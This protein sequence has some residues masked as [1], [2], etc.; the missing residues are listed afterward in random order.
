MQTTARQW[1]VWP[2]APSQRQTRLIATRAASAQHCNLA[3][4]SPCRLVVS[5]CS[6]STAGKLVSHNESPEPIWAIKPCLDQVGRRSGHRQ[7]GHDGHLQ[8][9]GLSPRGVTI[10]ERVEAF[11]GRPLKG[12]W[13]YLWRNATYIKVRRSGRIVSVAA[14]AYRLP[15]R[16]R[17]ALVI[18]IQPSEA[19][20]FW[21]DLHRLTAP[22]KLWTK[23]IEPSRSRHS[24]LAEQMLR[25]INKWP[26]TRC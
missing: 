21:D 1:R 9:T 7:K 26:L 25:A 23:L 10:D 19:K 3:S 12:K 15:D 5:V 11:L 6:C 18:A 2:P 16:H 17:E 20:V 8:E 14:T 13:P 4:S 22:K 24:E